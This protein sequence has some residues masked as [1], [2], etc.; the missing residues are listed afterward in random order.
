MAEIVTLQIGQ[1]GNQVG[2]EFFTCIHNNT[3]N[4]VISNTFFTNIDGNR[5]ARAILVDTEAKVVTNCLARKRG[6]AWSYHKSNAI[7]KQSG[8][9]NNWAFGFNVHGPSLVDSV[10]ESVRK[11]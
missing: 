11:V 4:N 9:G 6:E 5:V 3:S 2:Q 10:L 1:C 8:S 7:V